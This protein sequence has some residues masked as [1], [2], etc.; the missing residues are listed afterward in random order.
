MTHPALPSRF[1]ILGVTLRWANLFEPYSSP[2][3]YR[4]DAGR[5]IGRYGVTFLHDFLPTPVNALVK[6]TRDDNMVILG[7]RF[8]PPIIPDDPNMMRA[9]IADATMC[10][11]PLDRLLCGQKVDVAGNVYENRGHTL[12]RTT[13]PG[14]PL[15]GLGLLV[16]RLAV[17]PLRQAFEDY[18]DE[19]FEAVE[20]PTDEQ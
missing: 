2:A 4:D 18:M 15:Y 3:N 13:T 19:A 10:R 1:A 14:A 6:S 5:N 9:L 8:V 12:H 11:V 7:T 17:E 20:A 16:V